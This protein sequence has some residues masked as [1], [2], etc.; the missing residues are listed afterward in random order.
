LLLWDFN[1]S[2]E[3]TETRPIKRNGQ[4]MTECRFR[5]TAK[6]RGKEVS[7]TR[8]RATSADEAWKVEQVAL[9]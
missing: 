4:T 5:A 1:S 2:A 7:T 8:V 9:E 3:L 6:Q